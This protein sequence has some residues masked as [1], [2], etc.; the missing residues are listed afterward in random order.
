VP[1]QHGHGHP[2][3]LADPLRPQRDQPG[4][5]AG[6]GAARLAIRILA[7]VLA[8][9]LRKAHRMM[10]PRNCPTVPQLDN[11]G[12]ALARCGPADQCGM[13]PWMA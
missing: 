2:E 5:I 8:G 6:T 3:D 7:G 10:I 1:A 12:L 4:L 13:S 11:A 9:I